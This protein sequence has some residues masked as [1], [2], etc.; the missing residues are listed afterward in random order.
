MILI[1]FFDNV[2]IF[3]KYGIF[4]FLGVFVLV[5]EEL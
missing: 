1:Y 3:M 4:F 2:I 5:I